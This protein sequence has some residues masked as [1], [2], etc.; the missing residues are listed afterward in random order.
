[1][2]PAII[3]GSPQWQRLVAEL[4]R[5]HPPSPAMCEALGRCLMHEAVPRQSVGERRDALHRAGWT[6]ARIGRADH[7]TTK[8]AEQSV[9]RWRRSQRA[10]RP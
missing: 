3:R 8:A 6:Y 7:V 5:G 9:Y 4:C 10:R 2:P 1:M